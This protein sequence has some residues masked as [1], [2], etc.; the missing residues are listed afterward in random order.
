MSRHIGSISAALSS[1]GFVSSRKET[2][3]R[4]WAHFFEQRLVIEPSRHSTAVKRTAR[5]QFPPKA[6][7]KVKKFT[8][9]LSLVRRVCIDNVIIVIHLLYRLVFWFT[10]AFLVTFPYKFLAHYASNSWKSQGS[11]NRKW[12]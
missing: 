11:E 1:P 9:K 12:R 8:A 2:S 5:A 7:C 6:R 3:G 10:S 4:A